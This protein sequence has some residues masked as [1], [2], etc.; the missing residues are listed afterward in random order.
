MSLN[1]RFTD[2]GDETGGAAG[3]VVRVHRHVLRGILGK[4]KKE[5]A[6]RPKYRTA[7]CGYSATAVAT[8]TERMD[9]RLS[10]LRRKRIA[11]SA[12][13]QFLR[14]KNRVGELRHVVRSNKRRRATKA[15]EDDLV[16]IH[17]PHFTNSKIQQGTE[18]GAAA[19]AVEAAQRRDLASRM[20]ETRLSRKIFAAYRLA[21][22][23]LF[24]CD[25]DD[26]VMA[27]RLD[28]S[29]NGRFVDCHQVFFE[30]VVL[31][32]L[33]DLNGGDCGGGGG[34]SNADAAGRYSN[35]ES[36]GVLCLR[37]VQHTIPPSVALSR[38]IRETLAKGDGGTQQRIGGDR[39][40]AGLVYDVG[41]LNDDNQWKMKD[42]RDSLRS[43][44][45]RLYQACYCRAVRR[46]AYEYLSARTSGVAAGA[47]DAEAVHCTYK[48][49]ELRSS[50]SWDKLLFHLKLNSGTSSLMIEL[51][52]QDPMRPRPTIITVSDTMT[53]A[54]ASSTIPRRRRSQRRI[55][56]VARAEGASDDGAK[57]DD[58]SNEYDDLIET[59]TLAF[60]RLPMENAIEEVAKAM[61]D[62]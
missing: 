3:D 5:K 28:V 35:G 57:S 36:D 23:S 4:E 20:Q 19:A 52:Y 22:I 1:D 60:R 56:E 29:V 50:P 32:S 26:E 10:R 58:K 51:A 31:P 17:R 53:T 25:D 62:W 40:G 16:E 30:L 37:L 48:V 42:L 9:S 18:V 59:A 43:F 7:A 13:V 11:L 14:Q 54:A 44:S 39:G 38:I 2:G 41:P 34:G 27:L 47:L 12:E 24:P 8:A 15:E 45:S 46:H 55:S 33:A 21:G 6:N 61:E 49:T